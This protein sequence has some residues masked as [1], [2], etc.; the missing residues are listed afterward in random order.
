M[1]PSLPLAACALALLL[2]GCAA[3][4]VRDRSKAP[5]AGQPVERAFDEVTGKPEPVPAK[6][7]GVKTGGRS[8]TT[9]VVAAPEEPEVDEFEQLDFPPELSSERYVGPRITAEILELSDGETRFAVMAAAHVPSGGYE[10]TF[11][12]ATTKGREMTLRLDLRIPGK[13]DIRTMALETL[14]VRHDIGSLSV[15]SLKVYVNLESRDGKP[16]G[17]RLATSAP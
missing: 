6:S 13:R 4:R 15:R 9:G 16:S 11:A 17:Y 14:N 3:P 8:K 7:R 5:V 10:L 2:V 12:G 1:T